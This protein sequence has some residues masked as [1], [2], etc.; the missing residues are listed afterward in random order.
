MSD[1]LTDA[2]SR[3]IIA[4]EYA[5]AE[6]TIPEGLTE[7]QYLALAVV[8]LDQSGLPLAVQARV[9]QLIYTRLT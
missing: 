3:T 7:R 6:G 8:A 2:Q 9:L 4:H 1:R 5:E